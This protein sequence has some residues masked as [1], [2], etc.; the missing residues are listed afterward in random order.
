MEKNAGGIVAAAPMRKGGHL[1][2][3]IYLL[4]GDKA[5]ALM[6]LQLSLK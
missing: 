5:L 2:I 1:M 3:S 4:S 6:F